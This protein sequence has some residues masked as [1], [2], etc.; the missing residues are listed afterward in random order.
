M[1]RDWGTR[2]VAGRG[3]VSACFYHDGLYP[4]PLHVG[5]HQYATA[6]APLFRE[7]G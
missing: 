7:H 5:A 1:Q 3:A 6:P 2:M 4:V